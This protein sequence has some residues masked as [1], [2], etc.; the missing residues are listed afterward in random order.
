VEGFDACDCSGGVL[1]LDTNHVNI[2]IDLA[3]TLFDGSGN[4]ASSA[5]DVQT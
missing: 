3:A 1:S 4:D 2:I 5:G